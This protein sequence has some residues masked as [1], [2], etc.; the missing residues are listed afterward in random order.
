VLTRGITQPVPVPT[1]A[2]TVA[3]MADMADE[4]VLT[5]GRPLWPVENRTIL[6]MIIS[7]PRTGR[8]GAR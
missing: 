6:N 3:A 7:G 5:P 8:R 1:P 2:V 4:D